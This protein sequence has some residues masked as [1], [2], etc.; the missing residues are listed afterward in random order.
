M[1][2]C[3]ENSKWVIVGVQGTGEGV[4]RRWVGVRYADGEEDER[5][6]VQEGGDEKGRG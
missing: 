3:D 6:V 1:C 4:W 5:V 2:D